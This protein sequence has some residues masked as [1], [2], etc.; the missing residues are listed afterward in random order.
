MSAIAIV[1]LSGRLPDAKNLEQFWRNLR[2]GVESIRSFSDEELLASGVSPE[3]L[4]APNYV[5]AG[6][7]LDDIDL[8]D[9]SFFG[10]T[11]RE[12]EIMDPQHRFF[13]ECAWHALEDA[14]YDPDTFR[15]RIGVYAGLSVCT[16]Y[17]NLFS[18]LPLVESVG[19]YQLLMGNDKDF[20][21]TQTSY[22]LNLRGPSLAVQTAC[23]SSLVAAHIACQ[24]LV[25]GEC[26]M[27]LAGG[28]NVGAQ[29]RDISFRKVGSARQTG[30][31]ERS[32]PKREE[33]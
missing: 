22:K 17:F 8:F 4:R 14:G 18:N 26:D 5:K 6:A 33:R 31:A 27:A 24:S 11:P 23:S 32:M 30:I 16:Y 25:A 15:G 20:L 3:D 13:L 1:G 7:V 2:D 19:M 21:P 10:F 28:V 12:A 29:R 9:A